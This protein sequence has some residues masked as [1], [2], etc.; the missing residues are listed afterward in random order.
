MTLASFVFS[1]EGN[2]AH[3][4]HFNCATSSVR[5]PVLV[6]IGSQNNNQTV[7]FP[8]TLTG[9][10]YAM[11]PSI[12]PEGIQSVTGSEGV[13]TINDNMRAR[14]SS[15]VVIYNRNQVVISS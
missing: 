9:T 1:T 8:V 12:L 6:L 5:T 13:C 3:S 2:I 4:F 15:I 11:G 10:G 7:A 14:W